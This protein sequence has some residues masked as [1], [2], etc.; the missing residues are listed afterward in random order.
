MLDT[1][2]SDATF[3]DRCACDFSHFTAQ[4]DDDDLS[5]L[6]EHDAASS[7]AT[8]GGR[9]ACGSLSNSVRKS[10]MQPFE[11]D[12]AAL[13]PASSDATFGDSCACGSTGGSWGDLTVVAAGANSAGLPVLGILCGS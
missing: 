2:S 7:H 5:S 9:C 8:F 13:D 4:T 1:A 3:D 10:M 6:A 11:E 12:L